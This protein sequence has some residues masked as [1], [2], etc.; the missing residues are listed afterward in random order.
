MSGRAVLA[1]ARVGVALSHVGALND[2]D[3]AMWEPSLTKVHI[4]R[5]D[6][7]AGRKEAGVHQHL[8]QLRDADVVLRNGIRVTNVARACLDTASLV[9]VEHA[10]CSVNDALHREL[11]SVEQLRQCVDFM[12][13]WPGS[14]SHRILLRLADARIESVGESRFWYLCWR[15]RLP[16]PVPQ[17]EVRDGTGRIVAVLDFAWPERGLFVEFDGKVKYRSPDRDA[18][19]VDVVL[20]EKRREELVSRLTGWR[21]ERVTWPELYQPKRTA[22][23]VRAGF[24]TASV[25]L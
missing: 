9:D 24:R 8:G 10:L 4:T 6:Q 12:E 22:A 25:A 14:L 5:E 19:A 15:E 2:W 13:Q 1:R 20:R 23:R 11:A 7:R 21:C 16:M 3:V 17:Y 18:N